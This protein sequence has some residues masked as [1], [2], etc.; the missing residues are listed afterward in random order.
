[1]ALGSRYQAP[2]LPA[3]DRRPTSRLAQSWQLD[4]KPVKVP[5]F[6]RPLRK[7]LGLGKVREGYVA[8][9]RSSPNNFH[10]VLA[11]VL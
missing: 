7:L 3:S 8:R 2:P 9:A 1:M 10:R 5:A 4:Y 6:A 11:R